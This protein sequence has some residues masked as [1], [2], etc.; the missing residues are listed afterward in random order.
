MMAIGHVIG[1]DQAV[2]I[3]HI[4]KDH[5]VHVLATFEKDSRKIAEV[6]AITT[7]FNVRSCTGLFS[8]M[9]WY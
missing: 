5:A 2:A 3:A 8:H 6:R 1:R 7:T 9:T 4:N